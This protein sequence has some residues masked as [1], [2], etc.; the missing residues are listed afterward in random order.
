[1]RNIEAFK[2]KDGKMSMS[3]AEIARMARLLATL[4]FIQRGIKRKKIQNAS[5][6]VT[7]R[8]KTKVVS[9]DAYIAEVV[10]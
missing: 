8:G 5:I 4:R 7:K 2:K 9:L 1:M 6:L 10:K 3:T